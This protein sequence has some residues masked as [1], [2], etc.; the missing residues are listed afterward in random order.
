[1]D[2]IEFKISGKTIKQHLLKMDINSLYSLKKLVDEIYSDR[3]RVKFTPTTHN[4]IELINSKM[5]G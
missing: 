5:K 3:T 1:M 2:I 4:I